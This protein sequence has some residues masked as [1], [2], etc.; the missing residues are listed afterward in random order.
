MASPVTG[1]YA[2]SKFAVT[3]MTETLR[4]ELRSIGS[5]IRVSVSRTYVME[6]SKNTEKNVNYFNLFFRRVLVRES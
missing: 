2:A 1:M 6:L 3:A 5:K 4:Q